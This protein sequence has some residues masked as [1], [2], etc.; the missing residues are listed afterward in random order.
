[1]TGHGVIVDTS[2][3]ISFFNG[4]GPGVDELVTLIEAERVVTTGI[5]LAELL[6]GVRN[7]GEAT[8]VSELLSALESYEMTNALWIKAGNLS[9]NLRRKGA[10]LP[11]SDIAI[12]TL[13]IHNNA[14]VLTIDK[15]FD[16]IPGLRLFPKNQ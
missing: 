15:H 7:Q 14:E 3:W 9:A 6:Q 2:I 12:A 1:M 10:T 4:K 13:A 8:R 11:L 16:K 5:I